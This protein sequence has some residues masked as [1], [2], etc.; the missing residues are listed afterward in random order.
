MA[1]FAK[2]VELGSVTKAAAHLGLGKAAVSKQVA[3]LEASLGL[4]LLNRTTRRVAP[5]ETGRL[6][7][8]RCAR[9]LEEADA[10]QRLAVEQRDEPSGRIKVAAPVAFGNRFVL[11]AVHDLLAAHPRLQA[12]VMLDDSSIDLVERGVDVAFRLGFFKDSSLVQRRLATLHYGLFASPEWVERHRDPESVE[13]AAGQDWI[14]LTFLGDAERWTFRR[15]ERTETVDVRSRIGLDNT[16]SVLDTA[17]AGL[18][19]APLLIELIQPETRSGRLVRLLPGYDLGPKVGAFAVH[20]HRA[21]QPTKVKLL[22]QQVAGRLRAAVESAGNVAAALPGK[23]SRRSKR[24][25]ARRAPG[26]DE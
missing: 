24:A 20:P 18:G 26:R 12:Q 23:V 25:P 13:E 17:I 5:T 6:F 1:I 11:P 7:Y 16:Q 10:A 9:L 4:R 14:L 3:S 8:E 19:V 15:G 2:V 21:F 22:V